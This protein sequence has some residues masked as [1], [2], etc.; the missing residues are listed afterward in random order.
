MREI[1]YTEAIREALSEAMREDQNVFIMGEDIGVYGG[2]FGV[3]RGMIEEFGPER[4]RH[5]PIAESV[6]AGAAVGAAI[7]GMRPVFELQ[8][9]DFITI[10][11]DQIHYMY[12][13]N[14]SIPLVM[15][16]PGGSGTGAAAQH[17]QSLE[18]WTAHIP[19][20]IVI[21]PSTAYDAKGLLHSAIANN[22][23]VMFYE[24]KL[25]YRTKGDV[26]EGKYFIP[27][28]V[29]DIKRQG[30]DIS[31][32]AT[33]YMVHKALE[34][35]E[36]LAKEGIDIE[37]VDPRTLVPLDKKTIVDSVKKTGRALVVTEAV[38]RSGF[39]SELAAVISEEESFDYLDHPIVRLAGAETPIPYEPTLEKLAVPQVNDIVETCRKIMA[40]K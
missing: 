31:V 26:P 1:T 2:A 23:P 21:Q 5:T 3:T 9:S 33:S 15:R 7:T 20:L 40:A 38:K 11:L 10:A 28:G 4:V 36:I 34:A 19:G 29:A 32:I 12:G 37:I 8:F 13:G 16:T 14:V 22:N 27:I 24:H 35:A 18:N 25:C 30:K 6:I 39:S 17:S